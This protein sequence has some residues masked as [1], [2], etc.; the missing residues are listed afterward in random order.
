VA[1]L[2]GLELP[3]SFLGAEIVEI[4]E[5]VPVSPIAG[6]VAVAFAALPYARTLRVTVTVDPDHCP[7]PLLSTELQRET[8][9]A[10]W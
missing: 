4:V 1:N 10:R 7:E 8:R 6:N 5:I 9:P 2:R 3:L